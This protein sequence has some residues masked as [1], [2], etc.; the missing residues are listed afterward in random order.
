MMRLIL[1]LLVAWTAAAQQMYQF[2]VDQ[3]RVAGPPDFSA[4]N[5]PLSRSLKKCQDK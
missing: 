5:Q 4:L 3:D 1:V 2:Y